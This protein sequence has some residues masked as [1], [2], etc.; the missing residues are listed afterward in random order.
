MDE[1]CDLNVLREVLDQLSFCF[2]NDVE[3]NLPL[4]QADKLARFDRQLYASRYEPFLVKRME[5][6][7]IVLRRRVRDLREV[8]L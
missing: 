1:D 2:C 4:H 7:G 5:E 8:I 6:M 3:Y